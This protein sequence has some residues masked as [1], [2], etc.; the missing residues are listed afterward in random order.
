MAASKF[1]TQPPCLESTKLHWHWEACRSQGHPSGCPASSQGP[2]RSSAA[3]TGAAVKRLPGSYTAQESP[4]STSLD[5][6]W[7]G[8]PGVTSQHMHIFGCS[9]ALLNPFRHWNTYGHL[10]G[11]T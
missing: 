9:Q 4:S 7:L 10:W 11:L 1:H 8:I 2:V 3:C 5:R 6:G